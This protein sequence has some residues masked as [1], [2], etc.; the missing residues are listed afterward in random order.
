MAFFTRR[1]LTVPEVPDCPPYNEQ[2]ASS[3]HQI[4]KKN[5]CNKLSFKYVKPSL[6]NKADSESINQSCEKLATI[7]RNLGVEV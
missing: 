2:C 4:L 3:P 1:G 5:S 7:D 6:N